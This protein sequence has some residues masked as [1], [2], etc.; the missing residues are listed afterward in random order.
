MAESPIHDTVMPPSLFLADRTSEHKSVNNIPFQIDICDPSKRFGRELPKRARQL[1]LLAYSILAFSSRH[2][3]MITGVDDEK[4]E[5]YHSHALRILIP[6]LDDPMSSLDENLLAAAVLLRL[7]EEMCG[8]AR[9]WNNIPDFIA[10]GGLSEAASWILLR[11]NLHISLIKGEPMQV[12]LNKYRRSRSFIEMTDEDFA[13]RIILICCQVLETFFGPGA[14]PD[15][16]TWAHLGKEV[17]LWHDSIPAHYHPYH[18]DMERGSTGVKSAFPE[19][20][21]MN[22]A[23]V[24]G[25][26]V[27]SLKTIEHRV[28]ADSPWTFEIMS[29]FLCFSHPDRERDCQHRRATQHDAIRVEKTLDNTSQR[30]ERTHKTGGNINNLNTSDVQ[31]KSVAAVGAGNIPTGQYAWL[32][33]ICA[34]SLSRVS[35]NLLDPFDTLCESPERLR[36]LLRHPLA[37]T[38]GEP[39]FRIDQQTHCVVLQGLCNGDGLAP[40]LIHKSLFHA[41]SLLLALAANNFQ[42]NHET[43]HHRSEVLSSLNRDLSQFGGDSTLLHTITAILMVISYEYRVR[44]TYPGSACAATHMRG[45]QTII[46]QP[47]ILI[48]QYSVSRVTQVQRALFWQ[49]IICSLA[50][51][52][53]RLLK[54]DNRGI[55]TLLRENETYRGYF[56]LPQG[57]IPHSHGWPAE[58]SAVFQDLNALCCIVDTIRQGTEASIRLVDKANEDTFANPVPLMEDLDDEGYPLCNSQAELQIR[59]VDL[60]SG[61]RRDGSQSEEALIYRACLFAAY[62]CTYRLSEGVWGGYFAPETCVTK[63]LDFMTDFT[64]QMSPWKLAPDITL[65][66]LYMAGGLTKSQLHKDRAVALVDRYR[67][68]YSTGY[69]QDWELVEMRLEKFIWCENVMEQKMYRFWQECQVGCC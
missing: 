16:E 37:K 42:P 34:N 49:D 57:F 39:L 46:S 24:M 65:W 20:W 40:L 56:T 2:Q 12:D 21:M 47:N 45:L 15:Y 48:R 8:C 27:S 14:Q 23:Q 51:G 69:D 36:Q 41:L 55:F 4:S 26:W 19:V 59:L 35:P 54:F 64:K 28:A 31:M 60:L 7:Y 38:A 3:V 5:E 1:P 44:D 53:P 33:S 50:T 52:A 67:C 17:A 58:A 10:E 29:E 22:P 13:N 68:F 32:N 62:L 30:W 6:I 25:L 43:M 61:T 9:L 63:I 18:S 66:L 11:Q